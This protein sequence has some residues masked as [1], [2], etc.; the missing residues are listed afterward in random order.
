MRRALFA[1]VLSLLSAATA[2]PAD[3]V[4]KPLGAIAGG[5]MRGGLIPTP[6][7]RNLV[8]PAAVPTV[9]GKDVVTP[10]LRF[11]VEGK[12]PRLVVIGIPAMVYWNPGPNVYDL[13]VP[14]GAKEGTLAFVVIDKGLRRQVPFTYTL[15]KDT[16]IITCTEKVPAGPWLGDYNIS[17]TWWRA[18]KMLP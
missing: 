3:A 7:G 8:I 18:R 1:V 13:V 14:E 9:D 11:L 16:L 10:G 2:V 4:P 6:D 15:D 17:G 5:W 12:T